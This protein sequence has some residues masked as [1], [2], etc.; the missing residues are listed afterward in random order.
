MFASLFTRSARYRLR[1][2]A[3]TCGKVVEEGRIGLEFYPNA[4]PIKATKIIYKRDKVYKMT[5]STYD[6][7][8]AEVDKELNINAPEL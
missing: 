1:D 7:W 2:Y 8:K 5:F 4:N 6:D 3:I